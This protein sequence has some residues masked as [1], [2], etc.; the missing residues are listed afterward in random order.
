[1]LLG[2][3]GIFILYVALQVVAQGALG[4][5][6]ASNTE[7]PLAAAAS[8]VFGSRGA[9]LLLIGMIVSIF[10]CL[11]GD[12]LNTPRVVFAAARDGL[13]PGVLAKVHPKH[14][15]P[16]IAILFYA[17][18]GC[19]FA[20]T[21]TFKQLAVV[22]SGSILL[23]YLGV[24]LAVIVLR[25]RFGPPGP[26]QFRIP[27]GPVVPILSSVVVLWLL[28][29]MTAG[30][31]IGIGALLALTVVIYFARSAFRKSTHLPS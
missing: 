4:P 9:E 3:S 22:A 25:R 2:V 10:G 11:S 20:L 21:G 5:D 6:L 23:I 30:E 1:L 17:A 14:H 28:S 19:V 29:Q 15:T 13:L 7:A 31:A 24:C 12:V 18:A 16:H 26:G 8:V 27:G